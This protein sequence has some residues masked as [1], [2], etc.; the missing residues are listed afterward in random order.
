MNYSKVMTATVLSGLLGLG[1]IQSVFAATNTNAGTDAK[2]AGVMMGSTISGA[3]AGGPLGALG[4]FLA[5]VWLSGQVQDADQLHTVTLQ[6][7]ESKAQADR[8]LQQLQDTQSLS[9]KYAQKALD[10]LQLE[11][12][13]KT[14]DSEL[15]VSGQ[16]RMAYL[17]AFL[18]ENPELKVR[19][20]GYTDPR[21][22]DDFN[23]TL[24]ESRTQ[25]VA[26]WLVDHGVEVSR[27]ETHAHGASESLAAVGD[28]DSYALERVVKIQLKQGDSTDTVAQIAVGD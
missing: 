18:A 25:S 9:Y 20:D 7:A 26:R 17:A 5:G 28:Y 22:A 24:S 21:G 3:V 11:L 19:L 12:L 14:G 15:T 16:D 1:G 8:L 23:L 13:F 2:Q 4:G 6:L 10:Q 27:I